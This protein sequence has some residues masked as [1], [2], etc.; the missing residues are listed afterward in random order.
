MMSHLFP[1][2]NNH[3]PAEELQEEADL[4]D[5]FFCFRQLKRQCHVKF[6]PW[7]KVGSIP[8]VQDTSKDELTK[9]WYWQSEQANIKQEAL[10]TLQK[11]KAKEVP[12]DGKELQELHVS[13]K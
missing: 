5:L 9:R 4:S 7:I 2:V 13:K 12:N 3:I 10:E 1:L 11:V 6:N 8:Y